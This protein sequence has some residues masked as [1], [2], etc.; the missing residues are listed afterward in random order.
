MIR[1]TVTHKFVHYI[2]EVLEEG[3]VYVSIEYATAVHR[4]CCGCA[5]EVVTPLSPADWKLTF[6]GVTIT[7]F[8]SIGN[9]SFLCQSHYWIERN[10]VVPARRWSSKEIG[11]SRVEGRRV[12]N[13][14][15]GERYPDGSRVLAHDAANEDD[16]HEPE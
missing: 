2:P 10:N 7:L 12:K 11:G 8:P 13:E 1:K 3:V 9:W 14:Y 6:D 4:C 16:E 15:Y 5:S